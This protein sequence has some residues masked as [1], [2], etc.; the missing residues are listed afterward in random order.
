[1]RTKPTT[2][3]YALPSPEEHDHRA[4]PGTPEGAAGQAI[5]KR[6]CGRIR[7]QGD[8]PPNRTCRP[9]D[10]TLH[11][12]V[13]LVAHQNAPQKGDDTSTSLLCDQKLSAKAGSGRRRTARR[14]NPPGETPPKG[15][16]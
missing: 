2:G 10:Q 5:R 16:P 8:S 1:M 12:S 4:G 14:K 9:S 6:A 7:R 15:K 11:G 3:N 13:E